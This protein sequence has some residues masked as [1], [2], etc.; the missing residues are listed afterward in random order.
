MGSNESKQPRSLTPLQCLLKNFRLL[1]LQGELRGKGLVRLCTV[2][3]H[4]YQLDNDPQWPPEGSLQ[5]QIFGWEDGETYPMLWP[6]GTSGLAL[7]YVPPAPLHACSLP[8]HNP[9]GPHLTNFPI[10]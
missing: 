1:G 7:T 10:L 3:W 8:A 2:V 4:Q 5:Y 9:R 6:F